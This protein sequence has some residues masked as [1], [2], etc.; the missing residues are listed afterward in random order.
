M[1]KVMLRYVSSMFNSIGIVV[2]ISHPVLYFFPTSY[3]GY[4]ND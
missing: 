3:S 4:I 2:L 1:K